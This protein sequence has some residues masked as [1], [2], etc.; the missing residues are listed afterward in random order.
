[1]E[2]LDTDLIE[3]KI[4]ATQRAERIISFLMFLS[5]SDREE[6]ES[7]AATLKLFVADTDP[8]YRVISE[9]IGRAHV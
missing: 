1:M 8:E 7:A 6:I 2:N 5:K 9:K 3:K 4:D